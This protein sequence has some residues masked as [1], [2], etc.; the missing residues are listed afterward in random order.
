MSFVLFA[1]LFAGIAIGVTIDVVLVAAALAVLLRRFQRAGATPPWRR[2]TAVFLVGTALAFHAARALPYGEV[3]PGNDYEVAARN[4]FR[5]GIAYSVAPGAAFL[6]TAL[7][8]LTIRQ[9][10]AGKD[11]LPAS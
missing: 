5:A 3:R 9:P 8:G 1:I 6:L 2:L 11:R 10:D 7:V 4:L